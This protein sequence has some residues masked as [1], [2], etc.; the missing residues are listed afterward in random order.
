MVV[1]L[2][3]KCEVLGYEDG[4]VGDEEEERRKIESDFIPAVDVMS[5]S[6]V[7]KTHCKDVLFTIA[8]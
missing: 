5:L 1:G 2:W 8:S 6:D 3:L 4:K 7:K